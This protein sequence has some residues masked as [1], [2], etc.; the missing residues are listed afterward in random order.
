MATEPLDR[1]DRLYADIRELEAENARLRE[2]LRLRSNPASGVAS[3]LL[4]EVPY[5]LLTLP[6]EYHGLS[7]DA[8]VA[9]LKEQMDAGMRGAWKSLN[10]E[11]E[12]ERAHTG[13]DKG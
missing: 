6:K 4:D 2:E 9:K 11:Y 8:F 13:E 7:E 1:Q 10:D 5:S 12:R 3:R